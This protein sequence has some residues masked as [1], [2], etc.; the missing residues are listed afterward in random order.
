MIDQ[1]FRSTNVSP[2]NLPMAGWLVSSGGLVSS[3]SADLEMKVDL[4]EL[5]L[6]TLERM[7]LV[8]DDLYK[9]V[10]EKKALLKERRAAAGAEGATTVSSPLSKTRPL[11]ERDPW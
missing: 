2:A 7:W 9:E 8:A 6:E 4:K 5:G 11:R 3:F 10:L 1:R